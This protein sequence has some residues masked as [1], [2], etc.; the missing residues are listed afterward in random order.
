MRV[1]AAL[2]TGL[3]LQAQGGPDAL[4]QLNAAFRSTYKAAKERQLA[5]TVLVL[6]G[7]R[8]LWLR[9]KATVA[10]A[11][12]RPPLYHRLKGVDHV[13]LAL[14]LKLLPL[15]DRPL[16]AEDRQG[17]ALLRPLMLAARREQ[18]ITFLPGPVRSR[19][20]Q[21]LDHC[22][23]LLDGVLR[24]GRGSRPLLAAFARDLAPLLM[25]NVREAAGLQLDA[26][27]GAVSRWR[28]AMSEAE[29]QGLRVVLM[30][31]HMPREGEV[32]WQYFSRLLRQ[33]REG[34]R[35]I[36]AEGLWELKDALDLL[37]THGV[38]RGLGA[39]F[40]GD[41]ERMHR[42]LLADA[43]KAWVDAHL[44]QPTPEAP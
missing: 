29:W 40:F 36:Y 38:D 22:V 43:A 24:E 33:G 6:D 13:A 34:D 39:S 3:M 8:I 12:V 2:L 9:G 27:H 30:S 25:A 17:L 23:A 41:P 15:E 1:L 26:L 32:N 14:Y 44:P 11:T 42:D 18:A 5:G 16:A 7:D 35:I 37:A 19:Q 21:I 20:E 10:E 4:E 28:Q 31:A